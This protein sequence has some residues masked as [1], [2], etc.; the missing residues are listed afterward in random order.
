M[1]ENPADLEELASLERI[2]LGAHR[3]ALVFCISPRAQFSSQLMDWFKASHPN[4][5][6]HV[7]DLLEEPVSILDEILKSGVPPGCDGIFIDGF[8]RW[9]KEAEA[10]A[11]ISWIQDLNALRGSFQSEVSCALVFCIPPFLYRMIASGAPDFISVSSG[12]LE[13]ESGRIDSDLAYAMEASNSGTVAGTLA[14]ETR[15]PELREL[16]HRVSVQPKSRERDLELAWLKS[17]LG[18]ILLSRGRHIEAETLFV[19]ALALRRAILGERHS[20]TLASMNRLAILYDSQGRYAEAEPLLLN[21][22]SLRREVLGERHPDTLAS[23]SNLAGLYQNQGRYAEAEPL[24]LVALAQRRDVLGERYPDA[25]TS[26]NDLALLYK[27][28]GRYAEAETLYVEALALNREVLGER[29]PHTLT[30][31]NNLAMLYQNQGRYAEAE[32][33]FLVALALSRE[34]LGERHP[35]TLTSL[36]NLALLYERQGRYAEAEP[37]YVDGLVLCR[38]VLGERHPDTLGSIFNLAVF[39]LENGKRDE[40]TELLLEAELKSRYL[41][42]Q[43]PVR[44]AILAGMAHF[45]LEPL[46]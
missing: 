42:A 17:E 5:V 43:V 37:L 24:F 21:A 40:G 45:S 41:D 29:H 11:S 18:I 44:A 13:F 33:L 16:I 38:E 10:G 28:Q 7:V 19:D 36:N 34:V 22:L 39:W 26:L 1:I 9:A 35:R 8:W 20:D 23:M 14:S 15:V 12:F 25:L 27:S 2:I 32:P 30:S 31:L 46:P 4:A 6:A 3:F